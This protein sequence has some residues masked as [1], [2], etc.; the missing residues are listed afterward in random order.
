MKPL[1]AE[2]AKNTAFSA[3][4][5]TIPNRNLFQEREKPAV[6][7]WESGD[8]VCEWRQKIPL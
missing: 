2:K 1:P 7:K 4:I 5:F 6:I 8:W 3:G